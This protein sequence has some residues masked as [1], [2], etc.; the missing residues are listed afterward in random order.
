M[1]A[2]PDDN[3]RM[4]KKR[5]RKARLSILSKPYKCEKTMVAFDSILLI[6]DA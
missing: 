6:P 4:I 1:T 2:H 3:Q 5:L